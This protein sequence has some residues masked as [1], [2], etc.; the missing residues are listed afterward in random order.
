MRSTRVETAGQL[1]TVERLR[2][3]ILHGKEVPIGT[4]RARRP[5]GDPL[6]QRS[7]LWL[8][9]DGD[10]AVGTIRATFGADC[11]LRRDHPDDALGPFIDAAGPERLVVYSRFLV[12]PAYRSRLAS[13]LLMSEVARHTLDRSVD[14]A[15]FRCEPAAVARF[16]TLG[17]RRYRS[18][19]PGPPQGAGVPMVLLFSDRDH[20]SSVGSPIR[21][22][23]PDSIPAEPDP[24][25]ARL[26]AGTPLPTIGCRRTTGS[27]AAPR[28]HREPLRPATAHA[29][30]PPRSHRPPDRS[31]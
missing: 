8:A 12:L 2:E 16:A 20:L 18:V 27:P 10:R 4:G 6:D 14:V 11:D 5:A 30:G 3:E 25:L 28:W 29:A 17:F 19:A 1:A 9:W 26:V 15:F 31:G 13:L 23:V 7:H 22:R 24:R 21:S